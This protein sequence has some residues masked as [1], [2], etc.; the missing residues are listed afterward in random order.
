MRSQSHHGPAPEALVLALHQLV[1]GPL[2][3]ALIPHT[4]ALCRHY[5]GGGAQDGRWPFRIVRGKE[6]FPASV[7]LLSPERGTWTNETTGRQGGLLDLI[8]LAG[9]HETLSATM[10]AARDFLEAEHQREAEAQRQLAASLARH[11]EAFCQRYLPHGVKQDNQWRV[12][13]V[14]VDKA[15]YSMTVELLSPEQGAWRLEATSGQGALRDIVQSARE[16]IRT[17]RAL[18]KGE[19]LERPMYV[20]LL[21]PGKAMWQDRMAGNPG[22]L[23]DL[24]CHAAGYGDKAKGMAEARDFL[25]GE[26][27]ARRQLAA[28]LAPHAEALCRRFLPESVTAHDLPDVLTV[29]GE[30]ASPMSIHLSGPE[31]G[32]WK[33]EATGRQ[34]DLL[35]LIRIEGKHHDDLAAAMAAGRAFLETEREARRQLAGALSLYAG[36]FCR[37]FL[38]KSVRTVHLPGALTVRG[39]KGSLTIRLSGPERGTWTNETTGRQGDLLDLIRIKGKHE[40]DLAA[41]MAAGRAFLETEREA[42]RQLNAQLA[43]HTEALCESYLPDGVK[44]Q[45]GQWRTEDLTVRLSGPLQGTWRND[46]TGRQGDLLDIIRIEGKHDDDMTGTMAAARAFLHGEA[47]AALRHDWKAHDAR[48]LEAGNPLY[49]TPEYHQLIGRT[50]DLVQAY[51]TLRD[52]HAFFKPQHLEQRIAAHQAHLEQRIAAHQAHLEASAPLRRHAGA[53]RAHEQHRSEQLGL[54]GAHPVFS[55]QY[56]QWRREAEALIAKGQRLL[57]TPDPARLA[58]TA[59]LS[60]VGKATTNLEQTVRGDKH[61]RQ[62]RQA[63]NAR[64]EPHAEALCQRY[65][66]DG[67]KRDG[68]WRV[69]TVR[70]GEEHAL[71]VQLSGAGKGTWEDKAADRRGDL[72]DLIGR[73]AA[74]GDII[75]AMDAAR[76]FLEA[77]LRQQHKMAQDLEQKQTKHKSRGHGMSL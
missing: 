47:Q 23:F 54:G 67:V 49:H 66:P 12:P 16:G 39:Q 58:E 56:P 21:G 59:W 17:A 19:T 14:V 68:Q 1:R 69:S 42:R 29:H 64:L 27:E 20:H 76:A 41:A 57:D 75:Q 74:D 24:I 50:E 11:A 70:D 73:T 28:A 53:V 26:R 60:K 10:M 61:F 34:G 2:D 3:A 4:E 40:N 8:R 38:L 15:P 55:D 5:L 35:D 65:L 36:A 13:H 62:S 9:K 71:T 7:A 51:A 37:R 46:I 6:R 52:P 32:T 43:P 44:Q 63:L 31:R 72:L 22:D 30:Q 77:Q 33:D 48:A 25:E 18:I 45:D